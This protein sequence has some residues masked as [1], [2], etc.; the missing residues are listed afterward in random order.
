MTQMWQGLEEKLEYFDNCDILLSFSSTKYICFD[1]IL[2]TTEQ[3][4]LIMEYAEKGELFDYIVKQ[5]KLNEKEAAHIF[6]QILHAV[7][8]LHSSSISHRDLKPE[9]LLI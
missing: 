5:K 7:Y 6:S 9:N 1:K 3:L 4:L 2:E 8:Y